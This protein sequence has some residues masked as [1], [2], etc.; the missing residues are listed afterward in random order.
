MSAQV[1]EASEIPM[2]LWDSTHAHGRSGLPNGKLQLPVRLEEAYRQAI[3]DLGLQDMAGNIDD[4]DNGP[5]GDQGEDGAVEHFAKRFSGSCG[6]IQ[7]YALDPH[8]T[9]KT[10]RNALATLFCAGTVR[11]LDIPL[12]AGA[13]AVALISV[14]AQLRAEGK[15]VFPKLNLDVQ[16]VGGDHNPH[17][18][19][20]A[21]RM[22]RMLNPWWQEQGIN[23][24]LETMVWDVLK[25][26][27]TSDLVEMW[28]N[29]LT[30]TVVPV[31]VGTNFSGFLG[32][33]V[34]AGN[35]RRWIDEAE[36]CLRQVFSV[37][38]GRRATTLWIEPT[39]KRA[40]QHFL[41]KLRKQVFE[42]FS[43]IIPTDQNNPT[44]HA[45]ISDPIVDQGSFAARAS[46]IHL[47]S[48]I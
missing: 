8:H 24:K 4:R 10:T 30:G 22:F 34:Q 14:V 26:E 11:M 29:G 46:G 17:Q 43:R 35:S 38:A 42:R 2:S 48:S 45:L 28:R 39:D 41:P 20:L 7:L 16:V 36:S 44:S 23:V 15:P 31:I 32:G 18:I 9:F 21:E 12:G 40:T 27:S 3:D 33:P 25:D 6:R 13:G 5:V 37:A 1:F 19:K 47:V